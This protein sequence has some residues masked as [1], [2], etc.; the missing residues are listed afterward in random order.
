MP[1]IHLTNASIHEQTFEVHG[2]DNNQNISVKSHTTAVISSPGTQ[3]HSGAIIALHDG[4]ESEQVEITFNGWGDL[5]TYDVSVIVGA[6]GNLTVEQVGAP[7]TRKGD[8]TFMQDLRAHYARAD[9]KT[10]DSLRNS[11]HLDSHGQVSRIDA[12]KNFPALESFVRT[13]AEGRV[14]I[15][16]GA[17][18]GFKGDPGDNAQSSG[19][20]GGNK[21]LQIIYSDADTP[22]EIHKSFV[23]KPEAQAPLAEAP[24][25]D[26]EPS[27]AAAASVPAVNGAVTNGTGT[28]A[29]AAPV[30]HDEIKTVAPPRPSPFEGDPDHGGPGIIL[31]NKSPR[32]CTYFF[33]NNYWNGNGTAGAN[34]DHPDRSIELRPHT[35][36]YI[37]LPASFKGRVQRGKF[38]PATW[39][40]FQLAAENNTGAWGDISLEQG[41]DGPAIIRSSSD[42]THSNGFENDILPGAPAA[43]VTVRAQD[44]VRVLASTMGN[45]LGG[46]NHAAID[47]ENKVVGQKKAYITGGEGTD[48]VNSRNKRLAVEFY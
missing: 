26:S 29:T 36:A 43:A 13:F 32:E 5:E 47:Y 22:A 16:I 4:H 2:F 18:Q 39:A 14:Y 35:S 37:S 45:W 15:G 48:V 21:D 28:P 44:K 33:F 12:P 11:V 17:W 19:T 3:Q 23:M 31:S 41:Y 6:G 46:P 20:R 24:K 7:S 42:G 40:E 34:F 8:P 27:V 30:V 25:S 1:T 38:I 9:A 10:K